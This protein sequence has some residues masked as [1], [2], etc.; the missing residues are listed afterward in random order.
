MWLM[1]E[2]C[3]LQN[4][5]RFIATSI[6]QIIKKIFKYDNIHHDVRNQFLQKKTFLTKMSVTGVLQAADELQL[7][8]TS[9]VVT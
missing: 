3:T 8:V 4:I 9:A 6:I 2:Y 1:R 5:S 7:V